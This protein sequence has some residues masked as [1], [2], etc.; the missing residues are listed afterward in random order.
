[1]SDR[2][3]AGPFEGARKAR[4]TQAHRP[5]LWEAM[6]GTVYAMNADREFPR[7]ISGQVA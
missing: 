5:A 2:R 7:G 4:P 3:H 6:L 1:M